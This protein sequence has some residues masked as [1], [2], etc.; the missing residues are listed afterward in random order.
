MEMQLVHAFT[1]NETE[2][3]RTT[4]REYKGRLYVD[5]RLYFQPVDMAEM[6]P[7]KKGITISAEFLPELKRAIECAGIA[8]KE[9]VIPA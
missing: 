3:I 7:S 1:K 5:L 4:V 6:V 9:M 2:E 8:I